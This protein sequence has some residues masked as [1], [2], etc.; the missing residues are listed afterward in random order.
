MDQSLLSL[1]TM[2]ST[3]TFTESEATA[4]LTITPIKT[5]TAPQ[6]TTKQ[7]VIKPEET[8]TVN[9]VA[10][11]NRRKFATG[12]PILIRNRRVVGGKNAQ[13]GAVPW[14]VRYLMHRSTKTGFL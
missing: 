14:Q 13:L 8:A 3:E 1:N 11:Y 7:S 9:A 6:E 4:P 12:D 10:S 2:K 5:I